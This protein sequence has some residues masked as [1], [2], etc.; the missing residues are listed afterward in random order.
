M[1]EERGYPKRV[2]GK[3]KQIVFDFVRRSRPTDEVL[4]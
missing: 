3:D 2:G 4:A 1:M